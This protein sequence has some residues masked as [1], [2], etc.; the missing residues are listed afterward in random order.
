[1]HDRAM[2]ERTLLAKAIF[3][4]PWGAGDNADVKNY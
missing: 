4:D 2:L 3:L 1:M